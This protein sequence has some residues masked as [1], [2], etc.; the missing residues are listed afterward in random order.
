MQNIW[1]RRNKKFE[2]EEDFNL[3][4]AKKRTTTGG[5]HTWSD[6]ATANALAATCGKGPIMQVTYPIY[7][8]GRACPE[9][10]PKWLILTKT[11]DKTQLPIFIHYNGKNHYNAIVPASFAT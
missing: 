6:G 1:T 10:P 4:I 11:G 2:T 7:K 8:N 3:Y 9:L 5:V